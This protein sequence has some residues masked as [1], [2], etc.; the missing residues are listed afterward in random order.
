MKESQTRSLVLANVKLLHQMW[1]LLFLTPPR[2]SSCFKWRSFP[3]LTSDFT[4]A[5]LL[6]PQIKDL[7]R[8]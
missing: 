1:L 8:C 3:H 4:T 6:A 7:Y 5:S 2:L